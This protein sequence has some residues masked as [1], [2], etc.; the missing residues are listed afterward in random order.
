MATTPERGKVIGAPP[1]AVWDLV[2]ELAAGLRPGAMLD[3]AAGGGFDS[4]GPPP[5]ATPVEE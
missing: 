2:D 3:A 5:A 1:S 4:P